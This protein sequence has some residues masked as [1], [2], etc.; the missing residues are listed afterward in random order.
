MYLKKSYILNKEVENKNSIIFIFSK[1][2]KLNT[3]D[4]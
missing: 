4:G 1:G 2:K 3:E